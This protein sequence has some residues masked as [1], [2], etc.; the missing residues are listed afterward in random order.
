M[1]VCS[2]PVPVLGTYFQVVIMMSSIDTF[3]FFRLDARESPLCQLEPKTS[4]KVKILSLPLST[5]CV[6]NRHP[7][8]NDCHKVPNVTTAPT[9]SSPSRIAVPVPCVPVSILTSY[10]LL[11]RSPP[12][13]PSRRRCHGELGLRQRVSPRYCPSVQHIP[14]HRAA[15]TASVFYP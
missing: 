4:I 12:S 8:F 5:F 13:A 6:L 1:A 9:R 14:T 2:Q 3:Y 11:T 10:S 15:L 7:L